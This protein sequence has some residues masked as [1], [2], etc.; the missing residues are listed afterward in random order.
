MN[1]IW[2]GGSTIELKGKKYRAFLNPVK[3]D[4]L[5][6]TQVVVY[7]HTDE[8]HKDVEEGLMINWPGE[9]DMS[10]FS[11]KGVE[12][13]GKD[14]STIA[15][16]FHRQAGNITWLG[17]LAEYP[18]EAFIEALGE[19]HVLIIPV[20]GKDVLNAKDAFKLVEE[21]EPMVVIPI[22]YGGDRDGLQPFIKEM[23]VKLPESQKSFSFKKSAL[24][25]EQME[26]VILE[27]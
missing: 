26:L 8:K 18:N 6:E 10:G 2:H 1:I 11:C 23:D 5:K 15:Y 25:Q 20:G 3:D 24:S 19:V 13:E 17:E 27:D 9:Y 16:T 22:C 4:Q 14:K 12:F 21:L 7:D